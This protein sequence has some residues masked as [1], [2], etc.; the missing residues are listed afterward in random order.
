MTA[1]QR[2]NVIL[3]LEDVALGTAATSSAPQICDILSKLVQAT[4]NNGLSAEQLTRILAALNAGKAVDSPLQTIL[5]IALNGAPLPLAMKVDNL[6][7]FVD[8][9][10]AEDKAKLNTI[11]SKNGLLT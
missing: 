4:G 6:L 8:A 3:R 9:V 10:P 2:T 7:S 5:Q 1:N 11:L